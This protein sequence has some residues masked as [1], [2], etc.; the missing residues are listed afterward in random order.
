MRFNRAL[1]VFALAAASLVGVFGSAGAAAQ[2]EPDSCLYLGELPYEDLVPTWLQMYQAGDPCVDSPYGNV[3]GKID[4][5]DFSAF[6]IWVSEYWVGPGGGRPAWW[7]VDGAEL[8]TGSAGVE[9][10]IEAVD[11]VGGVV[12]I[13][14]Q[15]DADAF[16]SVLESRGLAGGSETRR[17]VVTAAEGVRVRYPIALRNDRYLLRHV[18]FW[19]VEFRPDKH[20][21][22]DAVH[23]RGWHYDLGFV[24]CSF[25]GWSG[26]VIGGSGGDPG[27]RFDHRPELVWLE[28][29]KFSRVFDSSAPVQSPSN[30]REKG[31]RSQVIYF[32][33]VRGLS[34][35]GCDF[36]DNG[37]DAAGDPLRLTPSMYSQNIYLGQAAESVRIERCTIDGAANNAIVAKGRDVTI[38]DNH[39]RRVVNF[40]S[41]GTNE[42]PEFPFSG[43]IEGNIARDLVPVNHLDDATLEG[44]RAADYNSGA[45]LSLVNARGVVIRGNSW[46]PLSSV[47]SASPRRS[48]AYMIGNGK[49]AGL[50]LSGIVIDGDRIE[51]LAQL[52]EMRDHRRPDGQSVKIY[53]V[54]GSARASVLARNTIP[55]R[56]RDAAAG[57]EIAG[58]TA[59][60][61]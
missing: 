24:D 29:C 8:E 13:S 3:D 20:T 61:N 55:E 27:D 30:W 4:G 56:A 11:G 22:A 46:G 40:A 44:G 5:A 42:S 16:V 39:A 47:G 2:V 38:R 6:L 41:L 57:I 60:V 50:E 19:G 35:I 33:S 28:S 48:V 17:V 52:V 23:L 37:W 54:I 15:A 9:G 45:A 32:G 58:K 14:T 1:C 7:P 31:H 43:V 51:G 21:N 59:E 49:S 53:N 26:G 34:I 18:V 12:K 36:K 25:S 10:S